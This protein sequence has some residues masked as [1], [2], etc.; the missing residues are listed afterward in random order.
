VSIA[1]MS[2]SLV[3][4]EG[5]A[6]GAQS[7]ATGTSPALFNRQT[8]SYSTLLSTSQEANLYQVMVLHAID[9]AKVPLLHAANPNLKIFMYTNVLSSNPGDPNALA[10]CTAYATDSA[11][12][13][14]WFLLDQAGRRIA[15][16]GYPGNYVMDM[17]N[18]GYQQACVAHATTLA[19]QYGFDGVYFDGVTANLAWAVPSGT[20]VP[21]YPTTSSWQ[22]AV[23]SLV[24]YATPQVHAQGRLLVANIGG[25][26]NYPGLWQKWT[27]AMDGSEEESWMDTS[28]SY[29]WSQMMA[30]TA[31]SEANGKLAI[32]HSHYTTETGNTFGLA[33]MMLLAQGNSSY[34]TANTNYSTSELL[35]PEYITAQHLG[36]PTGPY[37]KL[38]NG[39]DERTF[40][41]GLVLVNPTMHAV[42]SFV[43]GG[44]LYS[45]SGLTNAQSAAL[46][47]ASALILQRVVTSPPPVTK[48]P[49][50]KTTPKRVRCVVPKL[51]HAKLARAKK[52]ISRAH[53]RVGR[54]VRKRSARRNR[55]HV[56][57]QSPAAHRRLAAAAKVNLTVGR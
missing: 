3:L 51:A 43:L 8:Y 16:S 44:G 14:T 9:H 15:L 54:I 4:P 21:Q 10:E 27:A 40:T 26:A 53:C 39:V 30:D 17:G 42:P 41:G 24:S 19:K 12:H 35:F 46:G 57:T 5:Q 29:Y 56:L 55:S 18:T 50:P 47:P 31:W 49:G 37:Q 20:S 1:A 22:T 6:A 28:V 38:A 7:A 13:P 52:L 11:S 48:A 45:G 33:S 2:A 32:L 23:Y 25:G 34:S 36:A